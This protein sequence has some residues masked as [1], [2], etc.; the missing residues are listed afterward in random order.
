MY[1]QTGPDAAEELQFKLSLGKRIGEIAAQQQ[2]IAVQLETWLRH[3]RYAD[4][5]QLSLRQK[6]T[7]DSAIQGAMRRIVEARSEENRL[8]REIFGV[9]NDRLAIEG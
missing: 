1:A 2:I 5:H 7:S 8:F 6:Q 4:T 3:R 9:E